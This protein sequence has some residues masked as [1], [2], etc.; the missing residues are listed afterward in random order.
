MESILSIVAFT[1]SVYIV[2]KALS[3]VG[4]DPEVA[5][6][7]KVRLLWGNDHSIFTRDL[8]STFR[9]G[10]TQV[11]R[12]TDRLYHM[13]YGGATF[14]VDPMVLNKPRSTGISRTNN[15]K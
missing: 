11:K 3:T 1:G 12:I 8:H 13:T 10:D 5:N 2:Y 6:P 15:F 9:P 4:G 14:E 7:K